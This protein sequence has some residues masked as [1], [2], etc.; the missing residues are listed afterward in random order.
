MLDFPL[1]HFMNIGNHIE[2]RHQQMLKR[3]NIGLAFEYP[4]NFIDISD[5]C[6]VGGQ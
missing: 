3:M 1:D 5:K 2:L 4:E 6:L